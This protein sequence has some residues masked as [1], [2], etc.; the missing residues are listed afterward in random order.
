VAVL[1]LSPDLEVVTGVLAG[2]R[3]VADWL[4]CAFV[5]AWLGCACGL[6]WLSVEVPGLLLESFA[7]VLD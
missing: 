4:G 5:A 6:L 2:L 3:G 7:K 1:L